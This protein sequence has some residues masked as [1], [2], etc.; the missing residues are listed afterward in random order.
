MRLSHFLCACAATA[1]RKPDKFASTVSSVFGVVNARAYYI[2]HYH[3]KRRRRFV[4]RSG[5]IYL[6][7][8]YVYVCHRSLLSSLGVRIVAAAEFNYNVLEDK[9]HAR[10]G[11]HLRGDRIETLRKVVVAV[12]IISQHLHALSLLLNVCCQYIEISP[13]KRRPYANFDY[14]QRA[15]WK[16]VC[17]IPI[18]QRRCVCVPEMCTCTNAP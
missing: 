11:I 12:P 5:W 14:V 17:L 9:P 10:G 1:H 13:T 16:S 2:Y 18:E 4:G 3:D 8:M 15:T 7:I 6:Y